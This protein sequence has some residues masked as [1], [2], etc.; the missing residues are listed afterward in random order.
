MFSLVSE[1]Q[2]LPGATERIVGNT[3]VIPSLDKS[4]YRTFAVPELHMSG[5]CVNQV[6]KDRTN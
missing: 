1:P 5:L 3:E 4:R 2:R 6:L